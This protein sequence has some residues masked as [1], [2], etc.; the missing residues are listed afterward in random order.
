M[1]LT[2]KDTIEK[3]SQIERIMADHDDKI[4]LIF[5]YLKQLDQA[6]QQQEDQANRKLIGFQR[7]ENKQSVQNV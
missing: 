2:Y 4:L 5:E 6:K 7:N 3:L 1:L